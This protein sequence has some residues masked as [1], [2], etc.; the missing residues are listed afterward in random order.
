MSASTAHRKWTAFGLAL[1]A[2]AAGVQATDDELKKGEETPRYPNYVYEEEVPRQTQTVPGASSGI[3]Y[4]RHQYGD[5]L[6]GRWRADYEN[7]GWADYENYRLN[8]TPYLRTYDTFGDFIVEGYDVF[9][10]EEFRTRSPQLG[11]LARKGQ[12]Y[13]NWLR[14]LV[15]ADDSYGGWNTRLMVGDFIH[16]TFTPLTLDLVNFNG[17]RFDA[18]SSTDKQLTL[19]VSRISDPMKMKTSGRTDLGRQG[20]RRN[21]NDGVY[22]LGGHWE[23]S[24]GDVFTL[25]TSYVNLHR[26]DSQRGFRANSRRGLAPQNTVPREIVV[27]FEDDS[28]EDGR[29]GAA[30]FDLFA[31]VTLAPPIDAP[32]EEETETE[33]RPA[34]IELSPGVVQSG[35]HL[36]ASGLFRS[37][38][39]LDVPVFIDYIFAMPED[40][41]EVE[42]VALVA[43]DYKI[44]MRQKHFFVTDP[45]RGSG[46]NRE[47][48][49]SIIRRAEDNIGDMSNK[50]IIHFDYGMATGVEVMGLNGKLLVPGLDVHGEIAKSNNHF[51][52]PTLPGKRSSFDDAAGYLVLEKDLKPFQLGAELFSVGARYTSYNPHPAEANAPL[53]EVFFFNEPRQ[54]FYRNVGI[55]TSTPFFSLVDD[56]DNMLYNEMPD[57]WLVLDRPREGSIFPFFDLDQD[58]HADTNRN[59]NQFADYDEPFL[60]YFTDP[61]EFYFGDDFNNNSIT[62]AWEDDLLANY[63]YY[64]DERGLHLFVGCEPVRGLRVTLGRYDVEQIAAQGTNEALYGRFDFDRRFASRWRIRLNHES[65][66]VNDDISN[67]YFRYILREGI[68]GYTETFFADRLEARDSFVNR[69]LLQVEFQPAARWNIAGKMRY[70]LNHQREHRFA[71]GKMQAEDNLNFFG[72]VLRTDYA[73]A[74]GKLEIK[75]RFKALYRLRGRASAPAPLFKN[76]QVLPI[77]RVDYPLTVRSQLRLGLQG[78]PGLIDRR[79]DFV[80]ETND[81]KRTTWLLMWFSQ[82]KYEGYNIGTEI[83]VMRQEIDFDDSGKEDLAFNR[84][85]VR[86][87]SGIGSVVR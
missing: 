82:T 55:V 84:F 2:S 73:Y 70:D 69:G 54:S 45:L 12:F 44:S 49:F 24:I 38:E 30:V 31:R 34:S 62:D 42:F 57:N 27:R 32:G 52:Y 17:L 79:L 46:E 86:F 28:P 81:S 6:I 40:A 63:P 33:L 51:Q 67:D 76:L 64:K 61:D 15:I 56:N 14:H 50:K 9:T 26:F 13:Q 21:I 78:L 18:I 59:R 7:Y 68:G 72:A 11:S 8:T 22:L 87:L 3:F 53:G 65:K 39:G 58:G 25:G 35:R 1:F 75:P 83:G 5:L 20:Q 85:F 36:E 10:V 48:G 77:L 71:T 66:D 43:N 29:G 37:E 74:L 80:D 47:T 60:M 4:G 41:V 16:T 19:V 23:I